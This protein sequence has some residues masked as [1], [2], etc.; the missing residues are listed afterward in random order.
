M[1]DYPCVA[2]IIPAYNRE[3][4]IKYCLDSVINQ[5]YKN[6]EIIVVDNGSSDST[7]DIV[8][9]Y[10]DE[11]IKIIKLDKNSGAQHARNVGIKS[12]TS[13]WITLLDSDDEWLLDKIEKQLKILEENNWNKHLVIHSDAILKDVVNNTVSDF[14]I[15]F[16]DGDNVYPLLLEHS[17][18]F[19][20]AIFTSKQAFE[21]IGYLDE[22]VPSYQEW[23]TSIRLAK[24][25]KFIQMKEAT[26]I[27]Y[28]HDGET[29]SKSNE[30]DIQGYGYIINKHR[31][32]IIKYC[33][34]EV[35]SN[36]LLR[37]YY[38]SME[39]GFRDLAFKNLIKVP[40]SA[41]KVRLL[42][43]FFKK[44]CFSR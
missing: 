9:Q 43:Q 19:F 31:K 3:K 4:T 8:K 1:T 32:D 39:W 21:E 25:C 30:R 22:D 7:A 36:H 15:P 5:T 11:R 20:Q 34:K 33:S 14:N 17:S 12:A 38:R 35:W 28:L 6:L 40:F 27:Y 10:S 37:Q 16:V 18:P 13:E 24:I 23:D 2:V 29:I 41:K 44:V 26:F 42:L